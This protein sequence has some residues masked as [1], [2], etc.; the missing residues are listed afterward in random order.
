MSEVTAGEVTCFARALT[1]PLLGP[2]YG[3][4]LLLFLWHMACY[5]AFGS[6]LVVLGV[7]R[8][9]LGVTPITSQQQLTRANH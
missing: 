2:I 9:V 6:W 3:A 4:L 8:S 5:E 1:K 7:C